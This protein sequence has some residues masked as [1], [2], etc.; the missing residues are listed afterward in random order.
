MIIGFYVSGDFGRLQRSFL[1]SLNP[2][3]N[4]RPGLDPNRLIVTLKMFLEECFE[5]VYFD[6]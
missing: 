5:K 1:N 6:K 3:K 4:G 2:C